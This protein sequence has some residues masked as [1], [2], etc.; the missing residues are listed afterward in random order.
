M[1]RPTKLTPQIIT[2][3]CN[4]LAE[5]KSLRAICKYSGMPAAGTVCRWLGEPQNGA[6]REQYAR[7]REA[8]AEFYADELID[9]ADNAGTAKKPVDVQRS[10]LQVDARK[11]VAAKLLPR[12]YG[13]KME[14][15]GPRGGAIP[16]TS[17]TPEENE[18][19]IAE[20][21]AKAGGVQ[22]GDGAA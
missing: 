15:S 12:K 5:G 13:D 3:I 9:I 6:F 11:W 4:E 2:R 22:H 19:R 14:L 7:A 8:Q 17:M 16:L 21:M 10:R 1:G 18:R 20:L